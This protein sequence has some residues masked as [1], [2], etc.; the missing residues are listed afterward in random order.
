LIYLVGSILFSSY[1]ALS[2][3]VVERFNIPVFQAIVFNY[4]TCVITGS[5]VNG[6]FPVTQSSFNEPWMKWAL[7]MGA[8][9]IITFNLVGYTVQKIGVAVTSV[10]HK[11]SLII[12]F[13]FSIYLYNETA[14]WIKITG[15]VVALAAVVLTCIPPE[16]GETPAH[17][18]ISGLKMFLLPALLFLGSGFVDTMVKYV[19][20]TYLNDL[21]NNAYLISAF[22]TAGTIG[23][24]LL[25]GML[26]TGKQKFDKRSIIAGIAIGIPNYFSIWCLV[27]VLSLYQ[28]NSSAIIP[29]NNMS[30]VLFSSVV[31]FIVFK[32]HL[33]VINWLGIILAIGAIA[34]IAFG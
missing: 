26:T 28:G 27:K 16:K 30:I 15:V 10:A 33:S 5:V 31:A 24:I 23:L 21:N 13:A 20:Q 32:E 2:F 29:I 34:L 9:F 14:T 22:A 11:L 17:K 6:N 18:H 25:I 8:M 3:K 4:I 19:E 7:I 12:P 1:L